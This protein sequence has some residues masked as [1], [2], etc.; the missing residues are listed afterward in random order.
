MQLGQLMND[1]HNSHS[2]GFPPVSVIVWPWP[3]QGTRTRWLCRC[4][5]YDTNMVGYDNDGYSV[6]GFRGWPSCQT[7]QRTL[8]L[9]HTHLGAN[10]SKTYKYQKVLGIQP[11]NLS[12]GRAVLYMHAHTCSNGLA[13]LGSTN[14]K[15]TLVWH[16]GQ[17]SRRI[18]C[19]WV[20]QNIDFEAPFLV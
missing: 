17:L 6:V 9:F 19:L 5:G 2:E 1:G 18:S 8:R 15:P 12:N 14:G 7:W 3:L 16:A 10:S 11:H 13:M 20:L 4:T